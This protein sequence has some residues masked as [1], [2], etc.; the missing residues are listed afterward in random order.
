[1]N[2]LEI[3]ESLT[4]PASEIAFEAS[5]SGGP[6]G[7]HVNKTSTKVTLVFDLDASNALT[8]E[9]KD[10]LREKLAS[11]LSG[12]GVLRVSSQRTRSQLANR[13]DAMNK[14]A[15]VLRNALRES[16]PR[17][18]TRPSRGAKKKR[19]EDKRKKSEIKQGRSVVYDD[20][21]R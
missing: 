12:E 8:D 2:D 14:L 21:D 1:M 4:I 19:L 18:K 20:H 7:Q 13:D 15:E 5:R 11:K 6:G 9:Q 17:R 3:D 10:R 16:K